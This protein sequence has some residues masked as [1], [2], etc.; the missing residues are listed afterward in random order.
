MVLVTRAITTVDNERKAQM[1]RITRTLR[2]KRQSQDEMSGVLRYDVGC[3]THYM[4]DQKG[5]KR[6]TISTWFLYVSGQFR[7]GE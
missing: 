3:L 6:L 2:K 1:L 7:I 5:L 4:V